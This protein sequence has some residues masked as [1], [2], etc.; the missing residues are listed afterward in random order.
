MKKAIIII[1]LF[2]LLSSCLNNLIARPVS[3]SGGWTVMSYNDYY[4]NTLLTH[5]SPTS[6]TSF[7][8]MV[9]YWQNKEFWI[10]AFNVNYLA[11]RI[12]KKYSQANIYLKG[13]LGLLNTNYEKYNNKNELVSYGEF[14]LDWETRRYFTSYAGSFIK[15]ESVDN[16]LMQKLRVGFAPYIASYGSLHTW[17]MYELNNMPEY[18]DVLVSNFVLRLFKSTNLLE[19]GIDQNKNTTINFIKRF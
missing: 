9:Q 18:E 12:N 19:L 4:R 7:G 6:K 10:N 5:Y 15:S 13:G 3:Y 11:K 1:K 14:A 8:Y 16:N 2:F 17:L